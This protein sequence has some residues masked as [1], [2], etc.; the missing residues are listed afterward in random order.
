MAI[1]NKTRKI[2]WGESGNRCA[3]CK[4]E[5]VVEATTHDGESVVGEECHIISPQKGG[6]RHDPNY[7]DEL[8]NT[9]ENLILLCRTDHKRVDDQVA[10]FTKDYLHKIKDDHL[11]WVSD[12]LAQKEKTKPIRVRR[13]E[14]S[15][16]LARLTSGKS[17][18]NVVD[19][20][21]A[22]DFDHDELSTD[23]EVELISAFFQTLQDWGEVSGTLEAGDR[24]KA[25]FSLNNLLY[26]I[27]KNGF[28]VFGTRELAILEG[29]QAEP[30]Y[31]PIAL[32]RILKRK[33]D[34]I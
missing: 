15:E 29:G 32:I 19:D 7:P 4:K 34:S 22:Y 20:V 17:L 3:I 2:L 28:L 26:R 10:T 9:Y 11:V 16:A 30:S 18:L 31:W 23:K 25:A 33:D 8:I 27:E 21:M 1:T 12:R 5:L 24:I 14:E 13:N 6:P